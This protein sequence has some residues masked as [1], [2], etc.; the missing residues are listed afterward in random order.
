MWTVKLSYS[1]PGQDVLATQ[2]LGE[3]NLLHLGC[4]LFDSESRNFFY[5]NSDL[6]YSEVYIVWEDKLAFDNW[7]AVHGDDW[8]SLSTELNAH[9]SEKGV[10]FERKFP[11]YEDYDWAIE[12]RPD[13]IQ[14]ENI[15]HHLSMTKL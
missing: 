2:F 14:I 11:P 1:L 10:V 15:F 12:S 6:S 5:I 9:G 7:Y 3:E 8:E 4:N 13:M